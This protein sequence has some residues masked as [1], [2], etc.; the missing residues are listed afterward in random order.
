MDKKW[1]QFKIESSKY[2]NGPLTALITRV[3]SIRVTYLLRNTRVTPNMVTVMSLILFLTGVPFFAFSYGSYYFLV[4]GVIITQFAYVLD[5]T[6]GELA[7]YKKMSSK[8]GAWLDSTFDRIKE[9]VVFLAMTYHVYIKTNN[10]DYIFIGFIAFINVIIAGYITD[11]K[12]NLDLNKEENS[13]L[14]IGTNYLVGLV[15]LII[16][17]VSIAALFDRFEY[18]LIFFCFAGPFMWLFQIF[19]II[20]Q[21]K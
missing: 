10:T 14:K 3:I 20:R 21:V 7:R 18:L 15:E 4:I 16:F 2:R 13:A 9:S 11:T 17:G 12:I 8:F 5:C 19:K 1:Q 6:D